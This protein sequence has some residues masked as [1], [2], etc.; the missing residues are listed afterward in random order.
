MLIERK[1]AEKEIALFGSK[2]QSTTTVA[3][4][5]A[6]SGDTSKKESGVIRQRQQGYFGVLMREPAPHEE[7][8][9]EMKRMKE[10]NDVC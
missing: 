2:S 8:V 4:S 1:R 6:G 5:T 10:R 3:D 9:A 7:V